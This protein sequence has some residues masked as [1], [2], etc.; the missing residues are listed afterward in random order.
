M[1]I[2]SL[3]V[4]KLSLIACFGFILYK[5]RIIDKRVLKFLT[6]FVINFSIPCLFFSQ[7]VKDYKTVL[8]YP[9][10]IFLAASFAIFLIGL[11][12]GILISLGRKKNLR[13]EF[14]SVVS[15]QNAGYLPMNIALFLFS[16]A[17]RDE[18]LIYVFL[19]L[20]GF[21]ILM[22]SIGTFFIFKRKD[23]PFSFKTLLNPPVTATLAALFFIYTNSARFVPAVLLNP[24]EMVGET[25]FVLS[26]LVLGCWLAKVELQD[27]YKRWF[28]LLEASFL[29]LIILPLLVFLIVLKFEL[30]SLFGLFIILEAAM[31]SAA[32]L[33]IIVDIR[34]ADSKFV[35][36]CVFITHLFSVVTVPLWLGLYLKFTPFSL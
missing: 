14:F 6:S 11:I 3:S 30:F 28:I 23:E 12:L 1:I 7:L 35:S 25:S 22:W 8:A 17:L 19:F 5:R 4:I 9:V 27:I 10:W 20:L 36:Q 34:G 13:R 31:P 15:F 33:P 18:F 29:K 32:S 24:M 26:M 21:N 16:K 2:I